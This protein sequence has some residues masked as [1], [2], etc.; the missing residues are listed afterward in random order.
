MRTNPKSKLLYMLAILLAPI[1]LLG[2]SSGQYKS[3]SMKGN[4]QV[5]LAKA[6]SKAST[7]EILIQNMSYSPSTLNVK[8]G[9]KV[10]WMNKDTVAHTVSSGSAPNGDGMFDKVLEPG[11]SFSHIYNKAGI[12][13]YFCKNDNMMTGTITVT[14]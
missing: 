4:H 9:E 3:T 8:K 1:L 10:T 7:A 2:W 14:E 6:T 11:K 5:K 13:P 12:F